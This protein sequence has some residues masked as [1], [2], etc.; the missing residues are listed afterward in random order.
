L[1]KS[2]GWSDALQ[3][4]FAAYSAN[5]LLPARVIVQQRGLYL[6][7]QIAAGSSRQFISAK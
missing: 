3:H 4:E 7:V 2:Y 5:G 6:L 1:P